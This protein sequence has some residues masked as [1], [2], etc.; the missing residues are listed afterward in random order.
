MVW[1]YLLGLNNAEEKKDW[2]DGIHVFEF[3]K[4]IVSPV[5]KKQETAVR[6]KRNSATNLKAARQDA[7]RMVNTRVSTRSKQLYSA[8]EKKNGTA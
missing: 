4:K 6:M 5:G 3:G 7:R 8:A 1:A 2:H